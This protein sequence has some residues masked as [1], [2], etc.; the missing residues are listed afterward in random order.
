[1]FPSPTLFSF[2]FVADVT[3]DT[4]APTHCLFVRLDGRCNV[5]DTYLRTSEAKAIGLDCKL[6]A[7]DLNPAPAPAPTSPTAKPTHQIVMT[8]T[9]GLAKK[10]FTKE[11]QVCKTLV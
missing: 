9:L 6:D 7:V 1:M 11:K 3:V 2:A 4:G 8:I 10:D 5:G